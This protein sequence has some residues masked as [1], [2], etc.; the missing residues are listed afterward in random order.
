MSEDRNALQLHDDFAKARAIAYAAYFRSL[1][2]ATKDLPGQENILEE[3]E[4]L[5]RRLAEVL[6]QVRDANDEK[7]G[8]NYN[9]LTGM[10][11]TAGGQLLPIKYMS[12]AA[13]WTAATAEAK[14]KADTSAK[15]RNFRELAKIVGSS[16]VRESYDNIAP[17]VHY[18]HKQANSLAESMAKEI[19]KNARS[20]ASAVR[21]ALRR[22]RFLAWVRWA[23]PHF[24]KFTW[25]CIFLVIIAD[26]FIGVGTKQL[27]ARLE[28]IAGLL[29][30]HVHISV[31]EIEHTIKTVLLILIGWLLVERL[32]PHLERWQAK[33]ERRQI[34]KLA[35]DVTNASFQI[36]IHQA[37]VQIAF[38]DAQSFAFGTTT[39]TWSQGLFNIWSVPEIESL[40]DLPPLTAL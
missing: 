14:K 31:D 13:I 38:S 36:R 29:A 24:T 20:A 15:L 10:L 19:T 26:L 1:A 8:E 23:V 3:L 27:S 35:S 21:R 4:Q 22:A 12:R 28:P 7:L 32:R 18:A 6:K 5:R 33:L 2:E 17:F 34:Q 37:L 40:E 9:Q 11:L 25:G 39:I 16:P 30:P